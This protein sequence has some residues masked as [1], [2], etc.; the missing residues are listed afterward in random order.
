MV[1]RGGIRA[2]WGAGTDM[3]G[4]RSEHVKATAT[5]LEAL[6][7]SDHPQRLGHLVRRARAAAVLD[8]AEG[9][10]NPGLRDPADM[11]PRTSIRATPS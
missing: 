4:R 6:C 9:A 2:Y 11:S 5:G 3:S 7:R 1:F 8:L 10:A